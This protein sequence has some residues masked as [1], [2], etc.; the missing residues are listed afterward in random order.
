[1]PAYLDRGI[2]EE[3]VQGSVDSQGD[4]PQLDSASA[5]KG[6]PSKS[7][8]NVKDAHAKAKL[9]ALVKHLLSDIANTQKAIKTAHVSDAWQA[10]QQQQCQAS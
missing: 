4:L 6:S 5:V 10:L 1:M 2:W 8:A 3:D 9:V 7:T